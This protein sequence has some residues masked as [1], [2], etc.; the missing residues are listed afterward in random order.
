MWVDGIRSCLEKQLSLGNVPTDEMLMM[1]GM[2]KSARKS[3]SEL[4]LKPPT[5]RM[6]GSEANGKNVSRHSSSGESQSSRLSQKNPAVKKILLAN[7]FCADCGA[8]D[9]DWISLNLGVVVCIDCSGVHRSLGVHV[10]KVRVLE[11]VHLH[12]RWNC[13]YTSS[14]TTCMIAAL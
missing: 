12:R 14:D 13:S 7:P 11:H 1:S 10:S 8:K 6:S 4:E 2:K 3:P 9:P 5:P